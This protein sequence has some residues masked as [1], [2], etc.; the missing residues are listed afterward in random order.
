MLVLAAHK[1]WCLASTDIRNAFILAPI[2]DEEEDDDD[3]VYGLFSSKGVFRWW[4]VSQL[5]I[6]Y[7][8]WIV[9]YMASGGVL[10][11]GVS[12]GTDA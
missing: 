5:S 8:E 11:C 7:G 2:K 4:A 12:S 1:G 10:D 9:L 3:T 6:S